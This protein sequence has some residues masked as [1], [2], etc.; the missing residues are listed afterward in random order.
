[1]NAKLFAALVDAGISVCAGIAALVIGFRLKRVAPV[2][3]TAAE[4]K[5]RWA[6]LLIWGGVIIIVTAVSRALFSLAG[7]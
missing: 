4:G 6:T 3:L 1:M 5:R 2:A 7:T